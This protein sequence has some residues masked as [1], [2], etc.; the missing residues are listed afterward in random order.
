ATRRK[1]PVERSVGEALLELAELVL[2]VVGETFAY[3]RVVRLDLR[4]LLAPALCVD[5]HELGHRGV[6]DVETVDVDGGRCRD[7]PD[8][9]VDAVARA[10]H[11]F[12]DPLEHAAVVTEAR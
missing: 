12:D 9:R 1:S 4:D 8:R 7:A 2:E 6:V 3:R 5:G 11:L 10:L